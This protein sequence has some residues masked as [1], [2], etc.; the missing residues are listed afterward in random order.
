MA[1]ISSMSRAQLILAAVMA[2]ALAAPDL[3][4]AQSTNLLYERTLMTAADARCRLFVPEVSAALAAG[5]AQARGAA[6]RGG[7]SRKDIQAVEARAQAKAAGAECRSADIRTAAIRVASAFDGYARL[8]RLTYPG[9]IA[10][11]KADRIDSVDARWRL[12]QETRIG[13]DAVTFGLAGQQR[14][15]ALQAM[16]I[17]RDKA[18][19]YGARIVMRD[20]DR[21]TGPYLDRWKGGPTREVP[22]ARRLPPASAQLAFN[23]Q[24]RVQTGEDLLPKNEK[25]GWTFRFPEAAARQLA[26]LDPRDAVAVDFLFPGDKVR[27][28]YIEVG[29]FAAGRAFVTLRN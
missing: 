11:W 24:A 28:A 12:S 27:R 7:T 3:G 10:P 16:A 15:G 6:L 19:P 22:L 9:D 25:L 21:T 23:A 2:A 26:E 18:Q 8:W 1:L 13:T 5:A 17:F 29:D 4:H 14:P 20:P